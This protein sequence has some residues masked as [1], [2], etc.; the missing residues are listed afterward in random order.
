MD[1]IDFNTLLERNNI[2]ANITIFL[3]NFQKNKKNISI[4]RGIY[5]YGKSGSGKTYFVKTLLESLGYDIIFYDSGDFRNK[6]I[7]DAIKHNNMSDVNVLSLLTKKYKPL[8]I[9]MDE[10]DAMNNGDK[11]G[12]NTLIKLIRPKKTKKQKLEEI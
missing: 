2:A 9:I 6:Q 12:I 7:I 5:L 11:G 10:I 3:E 8:V 1:S 4:L